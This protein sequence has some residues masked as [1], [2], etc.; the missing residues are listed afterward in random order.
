[1]TIAEL[2]ARLAAGGWRLDR[3]LPRDHDHAT[4]TLLD[5]AGHPVAAQWYADPSRAAR[6]AEH[7]HRHAPEG[8]VERPLPEIV[9]QRGGADR[10]LRGL[11]DLCS[12][13]GSQLRAH[14][15]ERRAVVEMT[16][17]GAHRF[18]KVM[19]AERLTDPLVGALRDRFD[20]V[21]TPEV[22]AV[23]RA[24]G[25]VTMSALPGNTMHD[26]IARGE[27]GLPGHAAEVGR[28]LVRL[29]ASSV[30]GGATRHG[31][32]AEV[33]VVDR[34][35][36][37][38][39]AFDGVTLPGTT[40]HAARARMAELM[41]RVTFAPALLHRDLHDKQVLLG[42]AGPGLLDL[43]L[44]AVGDPALDLANLVVHLELRARQGLLSIERS[45]EMVEALVAGYAPDA[46][47]RA[48]VPA[49]LLASRLRLVAVYGFRPGD[50]SAAATLITDP[51]T[52][53]IT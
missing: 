35:L 28:V 32:E 7:T 6:V 16:D 27:P 15:P 48:A 11:A 29:H 12:R 21:P 40:V 30:P 25:T 49:Y 45:Q 13:P 50:A 31:A 4:A 22:L 20:G 2:D 1:M 47:T 9:A 23:D 5:P 17:G 26:A 24:A 36:G 33:A 8:A 37:L 44:L 14:R 46:R 39:E 19:R 43:D 52:C 34:W 3:L 10:R 38:A 51:L 53:E 41:A 18:V 42:P